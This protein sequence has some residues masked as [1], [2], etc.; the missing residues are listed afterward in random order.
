MKPLFEKQSKELFSQYN[1]VIKPLVAE[2]EA[3][4]EAMPQPLFNEI[5]AFTDHIA[6]CY[7]D[8]ISEE[9]MADELQKA[10]RHIIRITLDC[11]KCL[12][13]LLFQEIEKFEHRTRNINLKA[14]DNGEFY[15][16]YKQ[17]RREAAE[18][19]K[20]AKITESENSDKALIL[21]DAAFNKYVG[22]ER[23]LKECTEE[24]KW[25][26]IHFSARRVVKFL[27]WLAA[28]ILSG[29]LS[30]LISCDFLQGIFCK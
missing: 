25:A 22:I 23:L 30:M 3:R 17:M 18:T 29:L 7:R 20:K 27:L 13:I 19:V 21:Y 15:P 26:R 11:F 10:R 6:R 8:D 16:K 4:G 9:R 1:Y 24:V 28:A 5:R 12:N 14:I 2:I